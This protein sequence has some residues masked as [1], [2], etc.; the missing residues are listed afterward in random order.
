[1]VEA[2]ARLGRGSDH[3]KWNSANVSVLTHTDKPDE[4]IL[5]LETTGALSPEQILL[6]GVDEL[7]NRLQEFKQTMSELKA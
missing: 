4:H 6:A 3:A 1:K 5:T 2:Y 7:E